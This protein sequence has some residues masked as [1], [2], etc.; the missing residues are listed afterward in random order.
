M[1]VRFGVLSITTLLILACAGKGGDTAETG[2]TAPPNNVPTAATIHIEP[3]QPTSM[4]DLVVVID[5]DSTDGDNDAITYTIV[6]MV[7]E[8]ASGIETDTVLAE[9]TVRDEEW[10]VVIVANDGIDDGE[11]ASASVVIG[12]SAPVLSTVT[13]DPNPAQTGDNLACLPGTGADADG[14]SLSYTFAWT[15]DGVS[16][17]SSP[18]VLSSATKHLSEVSC[19][20]TPFDGIVDGAP[21]T[22]SLTIANTPPTGPSIQISG[23]GGQ[24]DLVCKIN[25]DGTDE[26]GHELSYSVRWEVDGASHNGTTTTTTWPNDTVPASQTNS[27]ETWTC[28]ALSNDG[29]ED[30]GEGSSAGV[31]IVNEPYTYTITK[32]M[33]NS[34]TSDCSSSNDRPYGCNGV[35]GFTWTDTEGLTPSAVDVDMSLGV[36]CGAG[37][38]TVELN[39]TQIGS[40]TSVDDCQ[41]NGTV[42]AVAIAASTASSYNVGGVN[43]LTVNDAGSCEGLMHNANWGSDAYG[44]VTLT[45]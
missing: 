45:Y 1:R 26:D 20:A 5:A 43:T 8:T 22:A 44:Q 24:D 35:W 33:L 18:E 41:C 12:N 34:L 31:T 21:A 36:M 38:R 19:T 14:D 32:S 25:I 10:T 42:D 23:S 4:D 29:Y 39:G 7:D 37:T 27:G 6:W 17:G 28:H 11:A 15:V 2:D 16:A 40:I 13:I 3:A 30:G 9:D